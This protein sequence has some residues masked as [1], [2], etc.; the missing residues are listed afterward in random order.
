MQEEVRGPVYT[1]DPLADDPLIAVHGKQHSQTHTFKRQNRDEPLSKVT[2]I[3][4]GWAIASGSVGRPT[5]QRQARKNQFDNEAGSVS[6]SP[7]A[8]RARARPLLWW[9]VPGEGFEPPTFGLQNRCTATVLTRQNQCLTR[10]LAGRCYR[11]CYRTI[12]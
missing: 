5:S 8:R 12:G 2:D 11:N 6:I 7:A 10:M 4:N 3:A 9:M 1:D